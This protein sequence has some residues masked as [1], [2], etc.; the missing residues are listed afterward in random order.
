MPQIGINDVLDTRR[1]KSLRKFPQKDDQAAQIIKDR[2][3]KNRLEVLEVV[4]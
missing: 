1:R 3:S 2:D 4:R